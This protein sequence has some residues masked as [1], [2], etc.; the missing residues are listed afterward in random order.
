[1]KTTY[2]GNNIFNN[3][4]GLYAID[5]C[6]DAN[7]DYKEALGKAR[8]ELKRTWLKPINEALAEAGLECVDFTPFIPREFNFLD[9]SLDLEIVVKDER[10]CAFYIATHKEELQKELDSNKSYD[11]FVATTETDINEEIKQAIYNGKEYQPD[12]MII[13][14]LLKE[15]AKDIDEDFSMDECVNAVAT[16]EDNE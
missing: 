2:N 3:A 7:F 12:I 6:S 14:F 13:K 11:G 9:V 4:F 15:V 8:Q 5:S 1:M 10:K 16:Y